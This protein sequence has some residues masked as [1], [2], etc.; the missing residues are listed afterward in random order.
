MINHHTLCSMCYKKKRRLSWG[1]FVMFLFLVGLQAQTEDCLKIPL[2]RLESKH[3][4]VGEEAV[5]ALILA[6]APK[7]LRTYDIFVSVRNSSVALISSAGKGEAVDGLLFQVLE[8]TGDAIKFR[9]LSLFETRILPGARDIAL[10]DIHVTG[11]KEGNT[12]MDVRVDAFVDDEGNNVAAVAESGLLEVVAGSSG[13]SPGEVSASAAQDVDEDDSH[14]EINGSEMLTLENVIQFAFN[15]DSPVVQTQIDRFDF[16]HDGDVDFDDAVELA[17]LAK[18]TPSAF[19]QSAYRLFDHSNAVRKAIS[20]S[21]PSLIQQQSGGSQPAGQGGYSDHMDSHYQGE[22]LFAKALRLKQRDTEGSLEKENLDGRI[23]DLTLLNHDP[24]SVK[25]EFEN[26]SATVLNP[27]GWLEIRDITG[28]AIISIPIEAFPLVPGDKQFITC[29]DENG[30]L[31]PGTYLA[32]G[33]ID[34]GT[35]YWVAGQ[36]MFVIEGKDKG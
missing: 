34:L 27:E 20:Q 36:R 8:Q 35:G 3:V 29:A 24:L 14:G 4:E 21:D 2:V 11:L 6:K 17:K 19:E 25:I 10:A 33:V 31:H 22:A 9:A 30:E 28:E 5:L 26:T 23:T 15:V 32:L 16:D 1:I 12:R 7:G 18:M 13:N